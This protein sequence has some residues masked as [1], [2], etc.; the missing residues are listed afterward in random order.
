MDLI[1]KWLQAGAT[2]IL[3]LIALVLWKIKTNDLPHI[4]ERL[5]RIE[6]WM[7]GKGKK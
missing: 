4:Y 6:G 1:L 7:E 3:G 2:P 5:G